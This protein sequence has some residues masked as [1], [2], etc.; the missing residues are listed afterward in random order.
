ML[1]GSCE[2]MFVDDKLTVGFWGDVLAPGS[3]FDP[4]FSMQAFLG[5]IF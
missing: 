2:Y 5:V 3:M 4:V 1:T